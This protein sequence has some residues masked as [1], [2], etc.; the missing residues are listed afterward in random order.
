MIGLL[1]KRA[2]ICEFVPSLT[3]GKYLTFMAFPK[4]HSFTLEAHAGGHDAGEFV[5]SSI[6]LSA[7]SVVD[8]HNDIRIVV[9]LV[10]LPSSCQQRASG[11]KR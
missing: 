5:P 7:L 10:L 9:A 3:V 4:I 11:I 6:P 2:W 8:D 1:A